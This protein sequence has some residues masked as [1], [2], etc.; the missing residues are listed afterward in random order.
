MRATSIFLRKHRKLHLERAQIEVSANDIGDERYQ[1]DIAGGDC[2]VDIVLRRLDRAPVLA[3]NIELPGGVEAGEIDDLRHAGTGFG[4]DE[5]LRGAAAREI[6]AGAPAAASGPL[7]R[8][9][10]PRR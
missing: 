1:H 4:G 2:R 6:A 9:A 7:G 5:S 8:R 10:A 3:E